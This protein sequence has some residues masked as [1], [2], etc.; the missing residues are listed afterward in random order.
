M[1]ILILRATEASGQPLVQGEIAEVSE[2][3]AKIL[4]AMGRASTVPEPCIPAK[5]PKK[6]SHE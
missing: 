2:E 1:K 3:D 6:A 4:I 5:K